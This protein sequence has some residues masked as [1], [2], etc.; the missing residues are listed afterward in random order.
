M[1]SPRKEKKR[2]KTSFCP[3]V[4]SSPLPSH[5]TI[6]KRKK[7][8]EERE[9]ERGGLRSSARIPTGFFFFVLILFR[10]VLYCI[11]FYILFILFLNLSLNISL[12]IR[13]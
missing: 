5:G 9:R 1:K 3:K 12:K 6:S 2:E 11:L 13:N 7:E 8:R 10:F 4:A